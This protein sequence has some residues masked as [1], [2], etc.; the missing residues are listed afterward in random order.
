[1]SESGHSLAEFVSCSG[2]GGVEC[3]GVLV[4][5]GCGAG[6]ESVECSDVLV[7]YGELLGVSYVFV[8]GCGA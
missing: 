3:G 4:A 5:F 8:P 7:S 1:M 6:W 2:F